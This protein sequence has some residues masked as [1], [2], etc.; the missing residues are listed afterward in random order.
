MSSC[1]TSRLKRIAAQ[2]SSAAAQ[3]HSAAQ[4]STQAVSLACELTP[5]Q[6][7]LDSDEQYR[8][9]NGGSHLPSVV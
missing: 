6:N 8:K 1:M 5:L 9:V 7:L 2:R 3:Q 4:C